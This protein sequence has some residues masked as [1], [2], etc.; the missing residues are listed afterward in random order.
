MHV[1]FN[2][3]MPSWPPFIQLHNL[4]QNLTAQVH[5]ISVFTRSLVPWGNL[6]VHSCILW[7]ERNLGMAVAGVQ[8]TC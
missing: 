1:S 2:F 7:L 8:E 6:R 3:V 4:T 5:E